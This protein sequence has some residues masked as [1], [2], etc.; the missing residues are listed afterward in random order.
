MSNQNIKIKQNIKLYYIFGADG[1]ASIENEELKK[2]ITKTVGLNKKNVQ[3]VYNKNEISEVLPNVCRIC[4]ITN[5]KPL[6]NSV[7]L[8]EL[9]AKII[10]DAKLFDKILIFGT[11]YGGAIANRIAEELELELQKKSILSK[12][13]SK[14]LIATFGSIYIAKNTDIS[15]I[16][17][18]N[19][20]GIGDISEKCLG[21]NFK[22]LINESNGKISIKKNNSIKPKESSRLNP[23]ITEILYDSKKNPIIEYIQHYQ[24]P[25][26]IPLIHCIRIS[27]KT[28]CISSGK[29]DTICMCNWIIH[30]KYG[31][32][33]YTLLRNQTNNIKT[34][35]SGINNKKY[36]IDPPFLCS[37][38]SIISAQELIHREISNYTYNHKVL[39][40]DKF[41]DYL[42]NILNNF[43]KKIKYSL[44]YYILEQI[45]LFRYNNI[46]SKNLDINL[47]IEKLCLY[48][49]I[50][51]NKNINFFGNRKN[52]LQDI[53][54]NQVIQIISKIESLEGPVYAALLKPKN[55]TLNINNQKYKLPVIFL[56]SDYHEG[57]EK[58]LECSP[59]K[60]CYS[61]YSINGQLP[62]FLEYIIRELDIKNLNGDLYLEDWI[63]KWI[64]RQ[65]F[66]IPVFEFLTISNQSSS[67]SQ[68]LYKIMKCTGPLKEKSQSKKMCKRLRVHSSDPRKLTPNS[69]YKYTADSLRYRL[70]EFLFVN[71]DKP[72]TTEIIQTFKIKLEKEFNNE[73]IAND[74][75]EDLKKT[76]EGETNI[77]DF[78]KESKLFQKHSRTIHALKK[79]PEKLQDII[80]YK[81]NE[82]YGGTINKVYTNKSNKNNRINNLIIFIN[83]I[84]QQNLDMIN[85]LNKQNIIEI[86]DV[87]SNFSVSLV[88][89]YTISRVLKMANDQNPSNL[90]IIYLG[91]YHIINIIKILSEIYD[92]IEEWGDSNLTIKNRKLKEGSKC[93]LKKKLIKS[94][95]PPLLI[96]SNSLK[97]LSTGP[98]ARASSLFTSNKP[99]LFKIGDKV[100]LRDEYY[101]NNKIEGS[102]IYKRGNYGIIK[103]IVQGTRNLG[104]EYICQKSGA[105]A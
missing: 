11:C 1:A 39:I 94:S 5:S 82:I 87:P 22:D 67:L 62:T 50:I 9:V 13:L 104:K 15:N 99:P 31:K 103:E 34:I 55:N 41:I 66:L 12:N 52:N 48:S 6:Q 29:S 73:F 33:L 14:I 7:F 10:V 83:C 85:E 101:K 93:I 96:N 28:I 42:S 77:V 19:Y 3:F 27:N 26:I 58:C 70:M 40:S 51:L 89:I 72:F 76:Y 79:L 86:L 47:F 81:I 54:I 18:L 97:N 16:N 60:N 32:I 23:L 95:P 84:I 46:I 2:N 53:R 78:L 45:Y 80:Y 63:D 69:E 64:L 25:T 92:K 37:V 30:N 65:K 75:L 88:D 8:N 98:L 105:C 91:N 57:S 100:I 56:L 61:L 36:L 24:N 35:L 44:F 49:N 17:I 20:L 71:L 21:I 68:T 90:S 38:K 43:K 74:I 102:C 59:K 4:F